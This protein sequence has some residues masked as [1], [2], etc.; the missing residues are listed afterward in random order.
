YESRHHHRN[1]VDAVLS[2]GRTAAPAQIAQ[3]TA[4]VCYM[5]SIAAALQRPL[6][7]DPG[8]EKFEGDAEANALLARPVREGWKA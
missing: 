7:F 3:R 6:K 5:G 4:T 1:F 8:A 2:R